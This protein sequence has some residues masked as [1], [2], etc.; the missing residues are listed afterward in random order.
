M[1]VAKNCKFLH[2]SLTVQLDYI[3]DKKIEMEMCMSK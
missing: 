1:E 2:I 3:W